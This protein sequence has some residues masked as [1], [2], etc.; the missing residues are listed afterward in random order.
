MV[1]IFLNEDMKKND[2]GETVFYKDNNNVLCGIHQQ[3]G[4]VLVWNDTINHIPKP[5]AMLFV[6]TQS[7]FFLHLTDSDEEHR[8]CVELNK[9]SFQ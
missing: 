7:S 4:R 1:Q 3:P 6:Q 5:P 2:Y 9:V 8:S